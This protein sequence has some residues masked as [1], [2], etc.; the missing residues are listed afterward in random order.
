MLV[1]EYMPEA[2]V[3]LKLNRKAVQITDDGVT[4]MDKDGNEEFLPAD[5]VVLTC[6]REP[7]EFLKE[8]L[9]GKVPQVIGIGDCLNPRNIGTAIHEGAFWARQV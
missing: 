9:T 5:T 4:I 3:K 8:A 1:N 7:N 2:G 6:G